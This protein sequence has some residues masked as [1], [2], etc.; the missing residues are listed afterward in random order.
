MPPRP[1]FTKEEVLA[2][3]LKIVRERGE[4][5]LTARNLGAELG[6]STRPLFTLFTGMEQIKQEMAMGPATELFLDS[7]K[8]IRDYTPAFKKFGMMLVEFAEN[9]PHLFEFLFTSPHGKT[10]SLQEWTH[11]RLGDQAVDIICSEYGLDRETAR[12]L[13]REVWLH[14]FALCIL[15]VK[16]VVH[17]SEQEV[18]ESLSRS[19]V[20]LL[21]I[22][23]AGLMDKLAIS[24]VL[25]K[26]DA[27]AQNP[28]EQAA[29]LVAGSMDGHFVPAPIPPV[30]LQQQ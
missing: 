15:R 21:S 4:S 6:S 18:S 5:A 14:C 17:L 13:F 24:P 28:S 25:Q 20:G 30:A 9:E 1:K 16:N 10:Q 11:D 19:F 3:A 8:N 7:C 27:N 26:T 29:D 22:A 12:T 2:A 23:K